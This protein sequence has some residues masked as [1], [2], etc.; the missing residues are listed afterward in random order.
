MASLHVY[1]IWVNHVLKKGNN[2]QPTDIDAV[3]VYFIGKGV[4]VY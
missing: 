3:A 4:S 2:S 1:G